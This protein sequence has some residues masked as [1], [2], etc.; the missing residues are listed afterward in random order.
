MSLYS[1]IIMLAHTIIHLGLR[2]IEHTVFVQ[3]SSLNISGP[4]YNVT[5]RRKK[6]N[7]SMDPDFMILISEKV[8]IMFQI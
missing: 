5:D 4:A 8:F 3:S 6:Q 2:H 7:A 1:Q